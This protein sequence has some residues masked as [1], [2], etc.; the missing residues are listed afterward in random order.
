MQMIHANKKPKTVLVISSHVMRGSVG[1][2]A[3]VFVLENLGFHVW[4][5]LTV[6]MPWQPRQGASHKLAVGAA[7]FKAWAEDI[8]ASPK[9]SEIDAV[10]TGYFVSAEQVEIAADLIKKLKAK[11]PDLVYLCDPIMGN[12]GGIYVAQ[13]VTE[14][15]CRAFLPLADIIKPNRNEL[16]WI[17]GREFHNNAEIIAAARARFAAP[18]YVSSAFAEAENAIGNLYCS[19]SGV[20]LARHPIFQAPVKGMGDMIAPLLLHHFLQKEPPEQILAKTAAALY[21]YLCYSLGENADKADKFDELDYSA[22]YNLAAPKT[23][24][25]LIKLA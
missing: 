6:T 1:S 13:G 20:W 24:L 10:I 2:R 5:M 22:P 23:K 12:E 16:E 4:N 17:C 11:K 25:A 8:A 19:Q 14:A 21:E 3:N 18:L 9:S 15:I 7:D